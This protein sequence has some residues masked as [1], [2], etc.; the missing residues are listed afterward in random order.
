MKRKENK[1]DCVFLPIKC[2]YMLY[3][4]SFCPYNAIFVQFVV[5]PACADC[6]SDTYLTDEGKKE[7]KPFKLGAWRLRMALCYP[8]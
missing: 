4:I 3:V 7:G 1:I 8:V 5:S 2:T 6:I